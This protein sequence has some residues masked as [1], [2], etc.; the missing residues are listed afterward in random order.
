M[1]AYITAQRCAAF[2]RF[3]E[4]L[5]FGQLRTADCGPAT[6]PVNG[7]VKYDDKFTQLGAE[8]R[9]FCL[10]NYSLVGADRR[11]CQQDNHWSGIEPVCESESFVVDHS[12][13]F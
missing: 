6:A 1:D 4:Y 5:L 7:Y 9:Y 2:W 8:V 3:N 11:V 10:G 12:G 13:P